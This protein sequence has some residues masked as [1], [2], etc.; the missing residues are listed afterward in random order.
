MSQ[1][2]EGGCLWHGVSGLLVLKSGKYARKPNYTNTIQIIFILGD[3][4]FQRHQLSPRQR[5][6]ELIVCP[7]H[8]PAPYPSSYNLSTH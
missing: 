7:D 4:R 3:K 6:T 2:I 1:N 8:L 5:D